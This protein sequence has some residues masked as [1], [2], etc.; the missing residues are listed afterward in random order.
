M[1]SIDASAVANAG[2]TRFVGVAVIQTYSRR[3]KIPR[4][5]ISM[6]AFETCLRK[7]VTAAKANSGTKYAI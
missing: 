3:R 4:S 6:S 1:S 5:D 7:V 2:A